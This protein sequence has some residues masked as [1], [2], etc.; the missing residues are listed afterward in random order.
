MISNMKTFLLIS[1]AFIL[2][3]AVGMTTEEVSGDIMK[4]IAVIAVCTTMYGIY[5][6]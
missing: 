2:L 5:V 1:L 6:H 4:A 3:C